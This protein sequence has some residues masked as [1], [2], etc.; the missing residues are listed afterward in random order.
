ML[1][2]GRKS[3]QKR[4][5]ESLNDGKN[6][7]LSG[8]F[9]IGRTTLIKEIANTMSVERKFVFVDFNQAPCRMSKIL[10]KELDLSAK[11]KYKKKLKYT[12]MR[13][14]IANMGLSKRQP[15]VIVLDNIAKITAH[16]KIFLRHLISEQNFQFIAI[17]DN[18][19]PQED[20]CV[21]K[22]LLIP[23]TILTLHNLK[24]KDVEILLYYYTERYNFH[25]TNDYIHDLAKISDGYPLILA[26]LFRKKKP[27]TAHEGNN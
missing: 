25:W 6:V 10:F 3:E 24:T 14:L 15:P 22:S 26:E 12:S 17:A 11:R 5:I 19:I 1:F 8:K 13:Y 9:G 23:F 2:A 4:I 20:L 18:F 7:I 16:K 21:L 27:S